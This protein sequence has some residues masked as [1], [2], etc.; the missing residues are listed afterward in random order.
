VVTPVEN[1]SSLTGFQ[2][3][4]DIVQKLTENA[5]PPEGVAPY[6]QSQ[7]NLEAILPV[8]G[9]ANTGALMNQTDFDAIEF[10]EQHVPLLARVNARYRAT[11]WATLGGNPSVEALE[12]TLL[13]NHEV[14][15]DVTHKTPPVGGHVLLLIGFN[16]RRKVFFA[17]NHWGENRFIEIKYSNDP[18][19]DITS[20][21]YIKDV[22]DPTFVQ[23][24]ACWL[25]N[26]WVSI[27]N[28]TFR[29][30]LRR[31]EDFAGSADQIRHRLSRRRRPRC[32]RPVPE[33]RQP[34][35]SSSR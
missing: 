16:R 1:N 15:C 13:A 7:G 19:W 25:G 22:V 30:L 3:S 27:S 17:K 23:N 2:G 6:I 31:S 10:C 20:G 32:E 24:Q 9:F 35:V 21:W 12:N 8:L 33:R 34:S 18:E 14:V 11:D 26:W 28:T 4:G 5:A 29:M